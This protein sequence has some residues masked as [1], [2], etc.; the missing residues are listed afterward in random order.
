MKKIKRL[1]SMLLAAV[2]VMGMSVTAFA[3]GTTSVPTT[4]TGPATVTP[5][6]PSTETL[7]DAPNASDRVDVKIGGISGTPTVT[8]YQIASADYGKDGRTGFI[9]YKWAEGNEIDFSE[10]T[11]GQIAELANAI[12]NGK[13]RTPVYDSGQSDDQG[14][15]TKKVAAG[16]YL[17]VITGAADGSIY[18]PILLTATYSTKLNDDGTVAGV[19]LI[20]GSV[21]PVKDI[22]Y[23]NGASAV[24]KKSTPSINKTIDP[25]TVTPDAGIDKAPVDGTNTTSNPGPTT[26]ATASVGD[27]VKYSITPEMPSYPKEAVNKALAISDTAST[28]LTFRFD[29]LQMV[30]DRNLLVERADDAENSRFIFKYDGKIIAYARATENGFQMTFDYDNLIYGDN[31]AVHVPTITYSAVINDKAVVGEAG[32]SNTTTLYYTNKPN[33]ESDWE[34]GNPDT[35]LPE[36]EDI[37][38]K[39]DKEVVYTYQLAFHKTG[40]GAEAEGLKGAVFGIYSKA[41]CTEDNLV[42]IVTTNENGYAVSSQVAAGTYYIKEIAAPTGYSLNDNVYSIKAEWTSANY[43]IGG[44]TTRRTYTAKVDEAVNGEQVG[45]LDVDGVFYKLSTAVTY[46]RN[47]TISVDTGKELVPAYLKSETT[48]TNSETFTETNSGAGTATALTNMTNP[49]EKVGSIP[50]TR[51]ASLPSTGGIGTTIFTI[52]G[53][54]IMVIAAGLFLATRRKS[55]E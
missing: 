42:D 13:L 23:L 36:G 9:Q 30:L 50:N 6:E 45:W 7:K 41:D 39:T 43:N 12:V 40:E 1:L 24:A 52:G 48:T 44:E 4:P 17:A 33:T 16:V 20:G 46:D 27:A 18:N 29:T 26:N 34:P 22:K 25:T 15:Y 8:L 3:N 31:G 5:M 54:A 55:E 21:G 47:T 2:M 37:K 49:S 53:C 10:A 35:K 11:S 14:V 38:E 32:N 19:E 51:L 28:G